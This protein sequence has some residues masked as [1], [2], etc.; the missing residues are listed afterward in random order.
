MKFVDTATS[1]EHRFSSF[2]PDRIVAWPER[3]SMRSILAGVACVLAFSAHAGTP[4]CP[5][6]PAISAHSSHAALL[7]GQCRLWMWGFNDAGELAS[8]SRRPGQPEPMRR[9]TLPEPVREVTVAH[10]HTLAITGQGGVLLWGSREDIS[11]ISSFSPV[12]RKPVHLPLPGPVRSLAA[13]KYLHLFLLEDGRVYEHGCLGRQHADRDTPL[14]VDGVPAAKAVAI[15]SAHHL[16]LDRSGVVYEWGETVQTSKPR[17]VAG[18]PR[19]EAIAAGAWHSVALDAE[20]GVWTWGRNDDWQL[21]VGDPKDH[22]PAPHAIPAQVPGLPP[23]RA[24]A[25][26]WFST[27]AVTGDGRVFHWGSRGSNGYARPAQALGLTDVDVAFPGGNAAVTAGIFARLRTGE[28]VRW[29][30][31]VPRDYEEI[32]TP[33]ARGTVLPVI[34]PR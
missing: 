5:G 2:V 25:A 26:G 16:A 20:G 30:R 21:G 29:Q 17:P 6:L 24:I 27:I 18:L 11:C 23:V 13:S 10:E 14:L 34:T 12:A 7:D 3:T 9:V 15:G 8:R 32:S 28:L 33:P 22:S 19:I 4:S 1:R 31:T